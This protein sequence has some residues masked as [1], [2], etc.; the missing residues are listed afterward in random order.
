MMRGGGRYR[1]NQAYRRES[2]LRPNEILPLIKQH[3]QMTWRLMGELFRASPG[4]ML[5]HSVQSAVSG[6]LIP[7]QVYISAGLI[8]SIVASIAFAGGDLEQ[9]ADAEYLQF[10]V[11][12]WLILQVLPLLMG[13]ISQVVSMALGENF[14]H[15][16]NQKLMLAANQVEDLGVF[17]GENIFNDS[18]AIRRELTRRP[19][20]FMSAI[21][22]LLSALIAL[23]SL[24]GA[25]VA[26]AWEIPVIAVGLGLLA[27]VLRAAT[28][29]RIWGGNLSQSRH[30]R[31]MDYV[32]SLCYARDS[33]QEIRIYGLANYLE[34]R[35]SVAFAAMKKIMNQTRWDV[36]KMNMYVIIP[37]V[38]LLGWL[39]MVII[40]ATHATAADVTAVVFLLNGALALQG[41]V[42]SFSS[43]IGALIAHLAYFDK[44]YTFTDHLETYLVARDSRAEPGK[45]STVDRIS[46]DNCSFRYGNE[47]KPALVDVS[48]S[49]THG[50]RIAIVGRNGAGKSTLMKLA[51]G[52]Y[53]PQSG[54]VSVNERDLRDTDVKSY[55]DRCAV[56][57][58]DFARYM[59]TVGE[60]IAFRD[61]DQQDVLP[62]LGALAED[63]LTYSS[64]LGKEFEGEELSVGQWQRLSVLRCLHFARDRDVVVLDEPTAAID[65]LYE[66][67]IF[68]QFNEVSQN[69][70]AFFVTHR[71]SIIRYATRILVMDQGRIVDD[72][73]HTEL[74]RRCD[75]Y[76][77]M[78]TAQ[79]DKYIREEENNEVDS[80]AS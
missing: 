59:F 66:E 54:Q 17:E 4:L 41:Q 13:V 76:H 23:L 48:F 11:V 30:A 44:F 29:R 58:Q 20:A 6:I 12:G 77:E 36:A 57:F 9:A 7:I 53:N 28:G 37:Q 10:F 56:C 69:K 26:Y 64:Q 62:D 1:R 74:M 35:F 70:L 61:A 47:P 5:I 3:F 67:E 16:L 52:L 51:L 25:V 34:G 79:A 39:L 40:G 2:P 31:M 50:E 15:R 38:A 18:T 19:L 43:Q 68:R 21:F 33:R 63:K 75:L 55:W 32:F 45:V 71:L 65:P 49:A 78:Y 14:L 24:S 22:A 73:T 60:N 8:G 46:F 72:G 80:D 42:S 27:L